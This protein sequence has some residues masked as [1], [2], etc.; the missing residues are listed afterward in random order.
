M[1]DGPQK[2]AYLKGRVLYSDLQQRLQVSKSTLELA[3]VAVEPPAETNSQ[4][5]KKLIAVRNKAE[6]TLNSQIKTI[7]KVVDGLKVT[8]ILAE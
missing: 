8:E 4:K 2:T 3:S 5:V 1:P 7:E 6:W